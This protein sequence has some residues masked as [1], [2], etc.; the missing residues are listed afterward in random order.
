MLCLDDAFG[1]KPPRNARIMRNIIQGANYIHS[2]IIHFYHLAALDYVKGPETAPFI[3]RYRGDYRLPKK[4]NDATVG[5]YVAALDIRRKAHE[6]LAVF[7]GKAPATPVYIPGGVTENVTNQQKQAALKILAELTTFVDNVYIP[8]VQAVAGAYG[9][10]LDIGRGCKNLLSYGLF[11]ISD[12]TDDQFFKRGAWTDGKAGTVDVGKITED[13][14]YAWYADESSG[15][16]PSAGQTFPDPKK[17]TGYSWLKAPRY[18]GK[19]HEVGPLARM[20]VHGTGSI[21]NLGEKAFSVMGRHFARAVECSL[22]A[23]GLKAMIQGL[24]P[25][26]KVW[27]PCAIPESGQG[28]GL[29][30]APRGALGHWISIK[31]YRIDNYQCVVPTTWNGSPRDD[32][33]VRGPIEEALIDTPVADTANPIELV[34][35]VRS[36][37]PC[38]ACAVHCITVNG[39]KFTVAV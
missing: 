20:W 6:L 14:K 31:N 11:P 35:V 25:G 18:E 7:G 12:Q 39:K 15:R 4:I 24:E 8:D 28:Y 27:T 10:W 37:D 3:P 32:R 16:H 17:E 34:R 38:I 13:V 2:H 33:G 26:D 5:N 30:E 36:F 1:V 21:R 22:V 29:T 23:H 19:P 9:D